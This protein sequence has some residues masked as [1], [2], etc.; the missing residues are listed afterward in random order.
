[1]ATSKPTYKKLTHHEHILKAPDTYIGSIK[2]DNIELW[3][4]DLETKKFVKKEIKYVP[5]LYKI[6]DEILVNAHDH[7]LRD[8]TCK[9]I[10]ITIDQKSG[11]ISVWND[12]N[13]ILIEVNEK[14]NIYNPELIFGHLLTGSNYD[15]KGKTWGGKNGYGAK[16]ANIYSTHFY[17]ETLDVITKKKYYQHFYENMYK[18]DAPKISSIHKTDKPYTKITFLPDYEKFGLKNLTDDM[19]GLLMKRAYD[20]AAC[21]CKR[22]KVYLNESLINIST[23]GDYIKM[24]FPDTDISKSMTYKEVNDCWKVGVVYTPNS[25]FSHISHVNGI[26]TYSPNG[27]THVQHATDQVVKGLLNYIKE[28]YKGI[29]VKPPYLKEN[30][31]IFIDVTTNDPDFNSQTK[32]CLTTRI[33]D[34]NKRCDVDAAFIN[35]VSKLGI[36]DDAIEFAKLKDS[37][38]LKK[39]DGKKVGK[40]L[41]KDK[42]VDAKWA[43]KRQSKECRLIITEGDSAKSFALDGLDVIGRERYGV[44]PIRGKML[45]VRDAPTKQIA[46]N[47]EIA[48]IK[49]IMGLKQ[50]VRYTPNNLDKLRYGGMLLL[51]DA[52]VDGSHIKGLIINFIH[53]FWPELLQIDGFFQTISTPIIKATKKTSK[54]T[55][56][57]FYTLSEYN[58]WVSELG[59]KINSWNI[60]YYKG[61]G[62][63]SHDEA[64]LAFSDFDKKLL[65]YVWEKSHNY[66]SPKINDAAEVDDEN[67]DEESKNEKSNHESNTEE[68]HFDSQSKSNT[69]ILLAFSKSQ[70]D[71]RKEWL[72]NYDKDL[73]CEPIKQTIPYSDFIN[74]DLKHF[75]NYDNIRSI[76]SVCDGLKPSQRKILF[77]MMDKNID[78]SSKE[79]KVQGLGSVV[80]A[81]TS[82]IHGEQSLF[83]TIINMAQNYTGSNNIN[84]LYPSGNFGSRRQGGKDSASPRYIFTY[85]DSLTKLIFRQEDDPV[86]KYLIEENAVVEPENFAPI[87][88]NILINGT[89]GIGTG[90]STFIPCY[91]I[92]DIIKNILRMI[93]DEEPIAM[94]PWYKGFT[95]EITTKDDYTYNVKGIYEPIDEYNIKITELPVNMWTDKYEKFL[96]SIMVT[97]KDDTQ[98]LIES[99]DNS[100]GNNSIDF[101]LTFS[102]HT[103][104]KLIKSN[105]LFSKLKLMSTI[106]T[107]NMHLHDPTGKIVK[108]DTVEDILREFY[109]Y[110]LQMYEV[111]KEYHTKLLKNEL[112]ILKYKIKFIRKVCK[113]EIIIEKQ[114]KSKIIDKLKELEFPKL[115]HDINAIDDDTIDEEVNN[116]DDNLEEFGQQIKKSVKTYDYVTNL[117]LFSLTEEKIAELEKQHA[118]KKAE[119]ELYTNT[120]VKDIWKMELK[121]L[122]DAYESWYQKEMEPEIKYK[123]STATKSKRVVKKKSDN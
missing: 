6:F 95:G 100:S 79:V 86:Y 32:E 67:S 30:M 80:Q 74:K 102:G 60:K 15:Q 64:K 38:E 66:E 16:L 7:S 37:A 27:G 97:S 20:I 101:T 84:L 81:R 34:F 42:L 46:T 120:P 35:A 93:N 83:E 39:S 70:A 1:M 103:L 8:A 78:R 123:K 69:S 22:V 2:E 44:F 58:I 82:Y 122:L 119:L 77:T 55:Q 113:K 92:K 89:D 47:E 23:F 14:E 110:R 87:I 118:D 65:S 52:D 91:N 105:T 25:T 26:W 13:G 21:D 114:K 90:Y 104:Q 24:Y 117:Q 51:T 88:P 33:S 36:V 3:V 68:Y 111:R 116:K 107:S 109:D 9:T 115:S 96:K 108:Y 73:I 62:T 11:E 121:E 85:L 71:K 45:N 41:D 57:I 56:K 112:N 59:T 76:P 49:Q 29:N 106:S 99:Y 5:G 18:K 63:S 54:K 12:G 94:K 17:V 4:V 10:K 72:K 43:G 31:T 98:A 50:N 75:S 28:K 53:T 40:I 61:L 19:L 48:N